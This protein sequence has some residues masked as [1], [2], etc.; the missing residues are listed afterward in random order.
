MGTGSI[1][2][3]Q[4]IAAAN[5]D[6]SFD[7][8][9]G[10]R[11]KSQGIGAGDRQSNSSLQANTVKCKH[12]DSGITA[13]LAYGSKDDIC[14]ISVNGSIISINSSISRNVQII[15]VGT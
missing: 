7:L 14:R 15:G 10:T 8:H 9:I 5:I 3:H 4:T 11:Y 6:H 12:T 13:S 2:G 1:T